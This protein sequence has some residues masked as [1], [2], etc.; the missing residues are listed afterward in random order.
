M[1][2]RRARTV[3]RRCAVQVAIYGVEQLTVDGRVTEVQRVA[4]RGEMMTLGAKELMRLEGLGCL[5]PEGWSVDDLDASDE[6]VHASY[7]Q[8]R[9]SIVQGAGEVF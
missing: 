2:A 1:S 6:A 5:C 9:T 8:A 7:V 3:E 4:R